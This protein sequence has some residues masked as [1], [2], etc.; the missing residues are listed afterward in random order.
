MKR[1]SIAHPIPIIF[2][3]DT[4]PFGTNDTIRFIN[5]VSEIPA[6]P[7]WVGNKEKTDLQI[8]LGRVAHQETLFLYLFGKSGNVSLGKVLDEVS[9]SFEGATLTGY[10]LLIDLSLY[11]KKQI[12]I[13]PEERS[14]NYIEYIKSD[15]NEVKRRLGEEESLVIALANSQ[16]SHWDVEDQEEM[17]DTLRLNEDVEIVEHNFTRSTVKT[18]L[19][20]V[21]NKQQKYESSVVKTI[22]D[23]LQ[24]FD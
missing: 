22:S 21:L 6:Y 15:L 24:A 7:V 3:V 4:H 23:Y 20:T 11:R 14:K 2:L 9:T 16:K 5:L 8:L 13:N 19:L 18:V 17:R 12:Q 10:V 1:K